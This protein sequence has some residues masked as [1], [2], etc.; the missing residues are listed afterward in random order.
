MYAPDHIKCNN[1]HC[2]ELGINATDKETVINFFCSG[3]YN[4]IHLDHAKVE[5]LIDQ[6]TEALEVMRGQ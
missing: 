4:E 6:L 3:T 2:I 5:E 1:N